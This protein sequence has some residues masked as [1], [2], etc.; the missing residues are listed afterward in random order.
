MY[1][2]HIKIVFTQRYTWQN[3]ASQVLRLV[4]NRVES[5]CLIQDTILVVDQNFAMC[6]V[7]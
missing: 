7:G 2:L 3:F 4:N 1:Y 6:N 5:T